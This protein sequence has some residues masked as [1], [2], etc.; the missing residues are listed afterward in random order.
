MVLLVSSAV[1]VSANPFK[2]KPRRTEKVS[3][4]SRV[5]YG[6]PALNEHTR[7]FTVARSQINSTA[8]QFERIYCGNVSQTTDL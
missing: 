4:S 7:I 5:S 1:D 8:T 3:A 6:S 2:L